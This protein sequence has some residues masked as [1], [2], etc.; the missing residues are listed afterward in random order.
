MIPESAADSPAE[1]GATV[2]A[3]FV[4]FEEQEVG[5]TASVAGQARGGVTVSETGLQLLAPDTSVSKE[6]SVF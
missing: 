4:S 5:W 3:K 1:V 6:V 2:S